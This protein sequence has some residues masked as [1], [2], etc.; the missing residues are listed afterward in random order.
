M[1]HLHRTLQCP[2]GTPPEAASREANAMTDTRTFPTGPPASALTTR[3]PNSTVT[4]GDG[5]RRRSRGGG[6]AGATIRRRIQRWRR[7]TH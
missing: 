1:C 5:G 6:G 7:C 3:P 2:S 4:V